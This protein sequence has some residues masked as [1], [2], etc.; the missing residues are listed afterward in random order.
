MAADSWR[1]TAL[2][3]VPAISFVFHWGAFTRRM[4][5]RARSQFFA[6]LLRCRSSFF[7]PAA[8]GEYGVAWQT[9]NR[10]RPGLRLVGAR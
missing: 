1:G 4:F 3:S 8:A 6:R 10:R 2:P 9:V 7:M 5:P